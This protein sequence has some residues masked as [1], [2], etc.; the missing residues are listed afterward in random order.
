METVIF[1]LTIIG[2]IIMLPIAILALALI[3]LGIIGLVK[4]DYKNFKMILKIW[5]YC[6]L[7]F[8]ILLVIH[9]II[10]FVDLQINAA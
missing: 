7:A 1:I 5:G 9:L 3:V 2:I 6:W 8:F 10:T 4:K